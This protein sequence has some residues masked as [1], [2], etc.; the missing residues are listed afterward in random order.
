MN[1][2]AKKSK[3]FSFKTLPM[4]IGRLVCLPAL[5]I[6]RTKKLTPTGECYRKRISGGAI[7][8]ANHTS[9]SDPFWLAR[10]FGI[11]ECIFSLLR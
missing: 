5:L 1:P 6:F 11:V 9:F 4:D 8:A 7:I 10:L 2:N 3:L